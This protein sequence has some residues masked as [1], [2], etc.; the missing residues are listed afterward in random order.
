LRA[1]IVLRE[2]GDYRAA[3]VVAL[4]AAET[5][6]AQPL[7]AGGDLFEIGAHLLDLVVDRRALG[8]TAAEQR[9]E[10]RGLAAHALGLLGD[11]VE[12]TL[13][14]VLRFRVAAD[15]FVLGGIAG[16]GAAV[17][18]RQ[19]AF[20]PHAHR[21][22]RLRAGRAAVLAHLSHGVRGRLRQRRRP[23]G[24]DAEEKGAGHCRERETGIANFQHVQPLRTDPRGLK[25]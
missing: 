4:G 2:R 17:D 16:T 13:L 24:G 25:A 11:P 21:I 19:L 10:A 14:P 7:Q 8:G 15:L 6:A 1:A 5:T 12:F 3:L 9:E 20:Q 23:H 22:G 18:R